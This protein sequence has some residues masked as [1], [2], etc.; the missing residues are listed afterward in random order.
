MLSSFTAFY[1]IDLKTGMLVPT[2]NK[3]PGEVLVPLVFSTP[4]GS[5]AMGAMASPSTDPSFV[6]TYAKFNFASLQP[7][8]NGTTKW[9]NV[10]RSGPHFKVRCAHNYL[11]I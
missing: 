5:A 11:S 3:Q 10:F 6:V 4:D 7:F 2:D 1:T 9:S 8:D